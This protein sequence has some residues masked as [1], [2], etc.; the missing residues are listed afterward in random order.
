M[1]RRKYDRCGSTI[2]PEESW[3][4]SGRKPVKNCLNF[5]LNEWIIAESNGEGM[6][7]FVNNF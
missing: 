6:G 7:E 5:N 4:Y 1:A 3:T 2:R